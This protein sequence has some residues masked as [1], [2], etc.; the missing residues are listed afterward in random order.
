MTSIAAALV[1]VVLAFAPFAA[2][3][4]ED[5][6][7]KWAGAFNAVGP[8]GNVREQ[9]IE[10]NLKHVGKEL[11]GTAGPDASRQWAITKGVVDGNT[12]TFVVEVDNGA[13]PVINFA[14]TYADGHLKGDATGD[15]GGEKRAAKIDIQRVK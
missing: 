12:I 2:R 13:G 7:G 14:L 8:D 6:T 10:L 1:A 15:D 11:T 5:F 9:T 4:A 3:T